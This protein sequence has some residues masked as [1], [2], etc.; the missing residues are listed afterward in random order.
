VSFDPFGLMQP[1]GVRADTRGVGL[2]IG[3]DSVLCAVEMSPRSTASLYNAIALT[4]SQG[5][6]TAFLVVPPS[7][8]TDSSADE[9]ALRDTLHAFIARKVPADYP[10]VPPLFAQV[11]Y[12]EPAESIVTAAHHGQY[13]LI[14]MREREHSWVKDAFIEPITHA[15]LRTAKVPVLVLPASGTEI[16]SLE[17]SG[18]VFHCGRVLVAFDPDSD[19]RE[20][21]ETAAMLRMA[22]QQPLLVFAVN[23]RGSS[24]IA[25]RELERVVAQY[26]L[27]EDTES[28]IVAAS[29]VSAGIRTIVEREN[30]GLVVMGPG[31]GKRRLAPGTLSYEVLHHG[32][33]LV[34]CVPP[35]EARE[36]DALAVRERAGIPLVETGL[37]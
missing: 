26:E 15:V 4:H 3:F 5:C 22:S 32:S 11:T 24:A 19:N 13:E 30:A 28:T 34:M 12:G 20:V 27:A 2:P 36:A 9:I 6:L 10:H 16:V 14:V 35:S 25:E 21:L 29:S 17:S 33:A 23:A 37:N 8:R 1:T 7:K 31:H 18:P